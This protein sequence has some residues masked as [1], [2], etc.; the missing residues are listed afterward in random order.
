MTPRPYGARVAWLLALLVTA[1]V[2]ASGCTPEAE[3]T[4]VA[5][6]YKTVPI[7]SAEVVG[8]LGHSDLE[9]GFWAVYDA[10]PDPSSSVQ[11]KILAVL[12]PVDSDESALVH[13]DGQYV[14]AAGRIPGGV[15]SR[16]AGPEIF[17]DGMGPAKEP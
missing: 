5:P 12:I 9:G 3:R 11:P 7:G 14:W 15:S 8:Y 10:K 1:V 16:M 17:V 13:F 6:Y 2:F 4:P